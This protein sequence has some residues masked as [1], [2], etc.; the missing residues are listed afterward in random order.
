MSTK[1]IIKKRKLIF[2]KLIF[3]LFTLAYAIACASLAIVAA[4]LSV[5][6]LWLAGGYLYI[7]RRR[8][9]ANF[10]TIIALLTF[11]ICK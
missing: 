6:L 7:R 3:V 1:Y 9:V 2:K 4:S 11:L 5:I 8:V 10:V